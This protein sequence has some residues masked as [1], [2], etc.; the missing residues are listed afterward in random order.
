[1]KSVRAILSGASMLVILVA[2]GCNE[3][4]G[5]VLPN[6]VPPVA[7]TYRDSV[8]GAGKVVQ[9][10]NNSSHHLY[11]VK[12]VGRNARENSSASVKATDHLRPDET[13]EV[14]WLEFESWTPAP[15]ETIEIYCDDYFVPKVSYI[16]EG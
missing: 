14:G 3:N 5:S 13:V 2:L 15:G 7:I 11:N 1:M 9:V 12:V 6:P 10:T 16:P 4:G 8:W